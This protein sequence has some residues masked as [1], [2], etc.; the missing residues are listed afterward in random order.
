[1]CFK[2]GRLALASALLLAACT[3]QEDRTVRTVALLPFENLAPAEL[4]WMSRGFS[5]SLRL[6]LAGTAHTRPLALAALRDVPASG[7]TGIIHGYFSLAAGRLSVHAEVENTATHRMESVI[8]LNG[9]VSGGIL[10]LSREIARRIDPGARELPTKN[11]DALRAYVLALGAAGTD[12][13]SHSFEQAVAADPCFGAAYLEWAQALVSRGDR[14]RASQVIAAARAQAARFPELERVRLGVIAAALAGDRASER[15]ALVALTRADPGDASVLRKL[16][17]LDTAARRYDSAAQWYERVLERRPDD[18]ESLN[19]LGY[20]YA[21]GGNLERAV[22]ALERYRAM[23]PGDANPLDSLADVHY[24]CGRFAQAAALYE[25]AHAKDPALLAGGDLYKAAWARLMQGDRRAADETFARFLAAREA[26]RDV[27]PYRQAQWEYVTGRPRQAIARLERLA[28]SAP[29]PVASLVWA[30]LG[31]WSI[32]AGDRA[33]A[34]E[35]ARKAP[36]AGPLPALCAFLAQPPAPAEVWAARIARILPQP[37]QAPLRQLALAYALLLS[38]DFSAAAPPLERAWN[39]SS[40]TSPD[41]PAVSLAW[42]LVETGRFERVPELINPNPVPEP[43]GERP[44]LSLT[45]PRL[46]YLRGA[47]A[48]KQNRREDARTNYKRFLELAGDLP[49]YFGERDRATKAL[50]R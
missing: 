10:P 44:F 48:E 21:W 41:C 6:Q 16:A 49:D 12:A 50:A 2:R 29:P 14:A 19:L 47:L 9:A 34:L 20:T 38:K 35:C 3:R 42:A 37:A 15:G 4:E 25:Q 24:Y 11:A 7:A 43:T 13:A 26:V 32:E 8:A 30:Q 1:V 17:D 33:R 45:F 39:A 31:F 22:T 27:V 28:Q 18:V 46:F 36:V 40:P 23:R 5:E